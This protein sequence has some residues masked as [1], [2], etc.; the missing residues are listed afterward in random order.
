MDIIL[1]NELF[2]VFAESSNHVYIYVCDVKRDMSRWSTHAVDFFDLPGEY[3]EHAGEIWIEKIHPDDREIYKKEIDDIFAG[4]KSKHK[5][6]YRAINKEGNYVWLECRGTVVFDEEGAP[7]LF[8]GMMTRLDARNK[9]DPLT[10]LKTLYEFNNL[11]FTTDSGTIMLV[12]VDNFRTV[13]NNY[14]YSFGDI[15]LREFCKRLQEYCGSDRMLYRLGG[16]EFL[17]VTPF[18]D[19]TDAMTFFEGIQKLGSCLAGEQHQPISIRVSGG[20]VLYPENGQ[21]IEPLITSLEH[22]LEHAK[23]YK[24]G[25]VVFFSTEIA[26]H[27]KRTTTLLQALEQSID[28]GFKGFELY[29]QP[30]VKNKNHEI[31]SCEALLRWRDEKGEMANTAEVIRILEAGGKITEVGNWVVEELFKRAK[32]WQQKFPNLSVGFN[33]SYLQFKKSIFVDYLIDKAKEYELDPALICIELTESSKVDDFV[34]LA[35]CFEKLRDFGFRI[36]LDDF[37]I[38]Y[39]TLLLIK[40]LPTDS[41]KIDHSFVR[42]LTKEN[43]IDLAIIDSVVSLCKR[44]KI[45]VVAEGVETEEV[46]NIVEKFP[47]TYLQGYYFDKPI[48]VEEFETRILKI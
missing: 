46:L 40:N 18:G 19:K 25:Q 10:N 41:V 8:A 21:R 14:G 23:Q 24:R 6:E 7:K 48:S 13:I 44:L 39:S 26:E 42:S 38:A 29:F 33:V 47:I 20:V 4:R 37:G 31:A 35:R 5:C 15:I 27:H 30:L 3:M 28:Q 36:S 45:S 34:Y 9:Y 17:V 12:G 22:S 11:D 1:E 32:V 2:D 43:R 16:D